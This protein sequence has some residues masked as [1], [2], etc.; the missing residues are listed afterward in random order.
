MS[1]Q[2][3]LPFTMQNL[4]GA[5]LRVYSLH[6]I[7][8]RK[9]EIFNEIRRNGGGL[10]AKS[11]KLFDNVVGSGRVI[12]HFPSTR[13]GIKSWPVL[14]NRPRAA[15]VRGERWGV[16][17]P[18]LRAGF[19]RSPHVLRSHIRD[20]PAAAHVAGMRSALPSA[21]AA[22]PLSFFAAEARI[23]HGMSITD[24]PPGRHRKSGAL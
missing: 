7:D 11:I 16:V 13:R 24:C 22:L 3:K 12:E 23:R 5:I 2:S 18:L 20:P 14:I 10:N 8:R 1:S 9:N 4:W 6:R 19:H 17:P 15:P 21:R